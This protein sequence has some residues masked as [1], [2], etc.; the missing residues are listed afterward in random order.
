MPALLL[1]WASDPMT[2]IP[3]CLFVDS[4][5]L[6][7]YT[8]EGLHKSKALETQGPNSDTPATTSAIDDGG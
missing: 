5:A 1:M 3:S 6:F 8:H 7:R 4:P 2:T